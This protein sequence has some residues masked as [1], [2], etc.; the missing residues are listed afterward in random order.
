MRASLRLHHQILSWESDDAGG[1]EK[2]P[3]IMHHHLS[4]KNTW[5][6]RKPSQAFI[7]AMETCKDYNDHGNVFFLLDLVIPGL[8]QLVSNF[9]NL[10]TLWVHS[11]QSNW[12]EINVYILL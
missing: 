3:L 12:D 5:C 6:N 10:H 1:P 11:V 7:F 4:R 9:C 2:G 8:Y